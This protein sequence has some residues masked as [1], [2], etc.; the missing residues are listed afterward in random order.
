MSFTALTALALDNG[1]R[2]IVFLAGTKNNL[3]D[4]T[5]KRLRK[6]LIDGVIANNDYYKIHA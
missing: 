4:Q 3:L 1:Y 2:V 5:S 6:D